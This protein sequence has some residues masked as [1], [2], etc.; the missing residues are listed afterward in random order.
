MKAETDPA[1][2]LL[3][4][5]EMQGGVAVASVS[6]GYVLVFKRT[7]LQAL[8]DSTV[9]KEKVLIFVKQAPAAVEPAAMN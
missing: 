1:G 5:A 4:M 9:D 8:L 3:E 2:Y 7:A 6:D